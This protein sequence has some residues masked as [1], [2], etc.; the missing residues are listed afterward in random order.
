MNINMRIADFKVTVIL[1]ITKNGESTVL[2]F[3]FNFCDKIMDWKE[4]Q[5]RLCIAADCSISHTYDA[6]TKKDI[7]TDSVRPTDAAML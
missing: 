3:Q 5:K 6:K 2:L 4:L 7:F 1:K